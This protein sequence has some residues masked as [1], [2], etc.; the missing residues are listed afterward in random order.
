MSEPTDS[1]LFFVFS[2]SSLK[3]IRVPF[4]DE[5]E[6]RAGFLGTEMKYLSVYSSTFLP[7][8]RPYFRNSRFSYGDREK[9]FFALNGTI[10]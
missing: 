8:L 7:L 6:I 3:H 9:F 5:N 10:E 4:S 1:F 2:L